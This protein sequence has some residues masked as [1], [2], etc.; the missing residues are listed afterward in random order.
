MLFNYIYDP[1]NLETTDYDS[2]LTA[3]K[4]KYESEMYNPND[5]MEFMTSVGLSEEDLE[6]LQNV[7]ESLSRPIDAMDW[8]ELQDRP[9][10]VPP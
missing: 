2:Y 5:D 3:I 9:Q 1:F 6:T 10:Y 4:A 8:T 7:V